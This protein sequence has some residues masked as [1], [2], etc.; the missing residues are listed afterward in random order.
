MIL[1]GFRYFCISIGFLFICNRISSPTFL[2]PLLLFC[3]ISHKIYKF[4]L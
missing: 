1:P 4:D 2:P 3:Y